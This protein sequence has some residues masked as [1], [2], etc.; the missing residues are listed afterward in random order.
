MHRI[1]PNDIGLEGYGKP[2]DFYPRQLK[3]LGRI[4]FLQSKA[5]D[6]ET[7][8]EV[9]EIPGFGELVEFFKRNLPKDENTICHGD[10]KIDN[11]VST[12]ICKF[13]FLI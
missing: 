5:V 9:G 2:A 3:A 8:K 4:S 6:E 7:G 10:Y 1:K 12:L 11:L 13:F